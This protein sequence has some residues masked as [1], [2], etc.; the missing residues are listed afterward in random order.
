MRYVIDIDG[1]I[2]YPGKGEG[3]YTDATPIPER[4]RM[5]NDLY[6]EGHEIIY[7][8]ARGMGDF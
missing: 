4:I 8:T 1:T 5:I 3:R 2:C 7:H 6:T